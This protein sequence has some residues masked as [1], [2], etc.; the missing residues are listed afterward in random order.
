MTPIPTKTADISC[1]MYTDAALSPVNL[2]TFPSRLRLRRG[3]LGTRGIN[4]LLEGRLAGVS[5][6]WVMGVDLF[7]AQVDGDALGLGDRLLEFLRKD[8]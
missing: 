7:G 4:S 2:I 6:S 1:S 8:A 5:Q 3:R